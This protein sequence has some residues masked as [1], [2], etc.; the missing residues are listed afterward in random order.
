M[1]KA[2]AQTDGSRSKAKRLTVTLRQERH[3]LQQDAGAR[4]SRA[5]GC[6]KIRQSVELPD[7]PETR[8]MIHKVRHLVTVTE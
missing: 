5:W 1:A 2:Q 8:G 6:G 7:T 3:R 4:R